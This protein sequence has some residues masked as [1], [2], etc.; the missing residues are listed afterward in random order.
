MRV[1]T[2]PVLH[3]KR[4]FL[5]SDLSQN[6]NRSINFSYTSHYH[7]SWNPIRGSRVVLYVQTDER[8]GWI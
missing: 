4:P 3:W 5:L 1:E 7:V 6:Y 2:K 8:T